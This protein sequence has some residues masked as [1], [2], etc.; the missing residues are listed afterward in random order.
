[1]PFAVIGF[2]L[3]LQES[4][5]SFTW[6]LALKVLLCMVFARTAAMAFNRWAD[7]HIDEKNPR[8]L[9]R[10]I[11]AGLI[12]ANAALYFTI[13]NCFAFIVT[14][15]F[16]NSLC[17]ALSFVALAVVLGYSYTKRFTALCH[18]VLGL[19]LSLAPIGAW[20]AV[21]GSFDLLP[22][23]FSFAVLCW[24]SGFDIIYALQDEQFDKAHQL[25]SIPG[26]FGTVKALHISRNLHIASSLFI[27]AAGLQGGFGAIY[28]IGWAVFSGLLLYQHSLVK[29]GDLSR[30][31]LAFFTT[32]GIASIVFSVFVLADKLT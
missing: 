14:T 11:P 4:E 26:F 16:I 28:F 10:E 23:L 12:S 6:W 9:I 7:R 15:W 29:P 32:N 27:M 19:G 18:L 2:A 21:T 1:M 5:A 17:F 3:A 22:I 31:N 30:V 13:L 8:T 25:H 24:V 20:L